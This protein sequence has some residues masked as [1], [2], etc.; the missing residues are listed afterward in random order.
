MLKRS[1]SIPSVF[2][3]YSTRDK[4]VGAK[5]KELL[6]SHG[7]RCFLAHEDLEVS[8]EWRERILAE[9]RGCNAFVALL[10]KAFRSSN[11]APQEV[12]V[13]VGRGDIPIIPLSLDETIPFGF[14]AHVQGAKL[15]N[16]EVTT[17]DLIDPLMKKQPHLFIPGMVNGVA[18]AGSYRQA[19]AALKLLVPLFEHLDKGEL[20]AL[21]DA[22]IKNS[23]VWSAAKCR[24]EYLPELIELR[25]DEIEPKRRRELEYQ[26]EKNTW[27]QEP[28]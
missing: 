9:L 1:L 11:W 7:T 10:S 26:I 24:T 4:L 6:E 23:Q 15:V 16:G 21:V 27:F 14:M 17:A 18:D 28:R 13:I 25:R 12:G 20:D 2:V 5:V 3:S 22:A 8:E 19:E